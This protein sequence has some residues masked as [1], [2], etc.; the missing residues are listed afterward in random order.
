MVDTRYLHTLPGVS[1]TKHALAEGLTSGQTI[2]Q[3][4]NWKL[5]DSPSKN[6]VFGIWYGVAT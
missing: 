1:N 5:F 6:Q 4:K 3:I 2:I